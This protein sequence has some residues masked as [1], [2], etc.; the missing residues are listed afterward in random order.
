ML[1]SRKFKHEELLYEFGLTLEFCSS[2]FCG[3]YLPFK[4]RL[5]MALRANISVI[6]GILQL[7]PTAFKSTVGRFSGG[8]ICPFSLFKSQIGCVIGTFF[9]QLKLNNFDRD[10]DKFIL[11]LRTS[12]ITILASTVFLLTRTHINV[13]AQG[14]IIGERVTIMSRWSPQGTLIGLWRRTLRSNNLPF[15]SPSYHFSTAMYLFHRYSIL[16]T[17]FV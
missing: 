2:N 15:P 13:K 9:F 16:G 1:A 6:R 7:F 17:S 14:L 11:Q 5:A 12:K 8:S 4:F 3:L 10:V